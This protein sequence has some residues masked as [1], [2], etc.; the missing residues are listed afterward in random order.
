MAQEVMAT[1]LV[2]GDAGEPDDSL[3]EEEE[4]AREECSPGK[5]ITRMPSKV[6]SRRASTGGAIV[7]SG[8]PSSFVPEEVPIWGRRLVSSYAIDRSRLG[9]VQ[10]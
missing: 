10:A 8:M 1:N 4:G 7:G 3:L 5:A 9:I 2:I 6:E